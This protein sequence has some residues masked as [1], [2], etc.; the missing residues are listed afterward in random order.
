VTL[1]DNK[2]KKLYEEPQKELGRI[3]TR[4]EIKKEMKSGEGNYIK[5]GYSTI[6]KI[7]SVA[8]LI[9]FLFFVFSDGPLGPLILLVP[10]VG[11]FF[12]FFLKRQ[13]KNNGT[14]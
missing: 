10:I 4:D 8:L 3:K 1:T 14:R 2:K 9:S 6:G 13:R 5:C 7:L 12:Y 11:C